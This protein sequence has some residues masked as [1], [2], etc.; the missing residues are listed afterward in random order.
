MKKINLSAFLAALII[1][2]LT[3][4]VSAADADTKE[5]YFLIDNDSLVSTVRGT[6]YLA[7]SWNYDN[8][9]TM[10][11]DT[12]G[13][14]TSTLTD[15]TRNGYT[16]I[17]R[18]FEPQTKGLL[19]FETKLDVGAVK[20]GVHVCFENTQ[21][22]TVLDIFTKNNV[23]NVKT[24][25][26]TK[27]TSIKA[28][29]G[30]V[31]LLAVMDL[32]AKT[33]KVYVD[34]A[35]ACD[36]SLG[37]F[38]D[39]TKLTFSTG[40]EDII[41]FTPKTARLYVNY[42]VY[43]TYESGFLPGDF[44]NS[45]A[46]IAKLVG[47]SLYF[48]GTGTST[49]TFDNI[50]GKVVFEARVY[51]PENTDSAYVSLG[52]DGNE[53]LRIDVSNGNISVHD[54]AQTASF[55]GFSSASLSSGGPRPVMA[56]DTAVENPNPTGSLSSEMFS[57]TMNNKVWQTIHVEADT[58]TGKADLFVNGRIRT[59]FDFS[60]N[61]FDSVTLGA[62]SNSGTQGVY[63]DDVKVYNICDY[64]DYCPQ[65]NPAVSDDYTLIMSV[66]PL[67]REG[68]HYGWDYVSPYEEITPVLGY[69]DEGISETADWEI[70]QM[71]E[72][73]I[74]AM[75]FC[76]YAQGKTKE[77]LTSPHKDNPLD[78]ALHDGYFYAKYK[79][80]VDYCIMWE[81]TTNTS[82]MT[83][84]E[85]KNSLWPF[86]VEY[87]FTDPSYLKI[88][89]KVFF[90]IY[91]YNSFKQIFGS[92]EACKEVIDFMKS[93]ITNYGLDGMIVVF[94]DRGTNKTTVETLKAIG[95]DGVM[96]Y[97]YNEYSYSPSYL[98]QQYSEAVDNVNSVGDVSFIP[99]VANGRNILGW[100]D[101]RS[102]LSSIEQFAEI[103]QYAKD[104]LSEQ[105][106]SSEILDAGIVNFSTW[107]EFAEGH[108]LAPTES[109]G[110]SYADEWRKAFTNA[111]ESHSDAVP[112]QA[113]KARIGHLYND[114]RTPI[115]ALHTDVLAEPSSVMWEE[116][117][118]SNPYN[119]GWGEYGI[120]FSLSPVQDSI[121][122][123]KPSN[124]IPQLKSPENL[125][126]NADEIQYIHIRMKADNVDYGKIFFTN[127]SGEELSE[128]KSVV[129]YLTK[130]GEFVDV[131]VDMTACENWTGTIYK[132]RF[133]L[134]RSRNN[135]QVDF[136]RCLGMSDEQKKLAISVDGTKLEKM[137]YQHI[138][139][140][141]EIYVAAEP[142]K[143]LYSA[144]NFYHEWN[145]FTEELYIKTGT[146]KE[147]VF[148]VG[149]STAKVN[150]ISRTLAAPFYL[151]D[152]IPVL[153][154]KFILDASGID[155]SDSVD[156]FNISV[157]GTNNDDVVANRK[158]NEWLFDVTGDLEGWTASNSSAD[159]VGGDVVL[160]SNLIATTT[161]Y[162][163]QFGN[164]SLSLNAKDYM[165]FE[166]RMQYT[167]LGNKEGSSEQKYMTLYFATDTNNSFSQDQT[168]TCYF[169]SGVD[170][171][172]GY[173]TYTFDV[174]K[175]NLWT[176]TITNL[177]FDPGNNNGLYVIDYIRL[178]EFPAMDVRT[179]DAVNIRL[180]EPNGLR[181]MGILSLESAEAAYE[182]GFI[183]TKEDILKTNG[184]ELTHENW[185]KYGITVV[186]GKAYSENPETPQEP[187]IF[188]R[189]DE[190]L[191]IAG[192]LYGI[193]EKCYDYKLVCRAYALS[194][195]KY[196]YGEPIT[197]SIR[198]VAL[199]L[200]ESGAANSLSEEYK[201]FIYKVAGATL[202]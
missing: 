64:S 176:G 202:P 100:E 12:R 157:R 195:N 146:N 72:H 123:V 77:A 5:A 194:H 134:V 137:T 94:S 14:T 143:G 13:S 74:D 140:D 121:L 7:S 71:A 57:M 144:L 162:D 15:T 196:Y 174:T 1:C 188:D 198:E 160:T 126:L 168:V 4:F 48:E 111:A 66:C 187:I 118:D 58:A 200:V 136:I 185:K 114:Y 11:V 139:K 28:K 81:D 63:F 132:F 156:G 133:D 65:P 61:G 120:S 30:M 86:W 41:T 104:A 127:D 85:F 98:S 40:V 6:T 182:Y 21:G 34:E 88:N 24:L 117:F 9:Y 90:E 191:V 32:D 49:K 80:Y 149:Q 69:Y 23:F 173:K 163:P 145:R 172:D 52:N 3:V 31:N 177:R 110:Y 142:R 27:A 125:S 2:S 130:A 68:S 82:S 16:A 161:G 102:P 183:I 115:R 17:N 184:I 135:F 79:D 199:E 153:P 175:N 124:S 73:G 76:W 105:T 122:T 20:N 43:E 108:W 129:F 51:A 169:S 37:S 116:Q 181:F 103:L 47:D 53:K 92:D 155:Y 84:D 39:F 44:T 60:S 96:P 87:Y 154:M 170:S 62:Y 158:P 29:M 97:A 59:T 25:A 75:Q 109:N 67:W 166:V 55:Y 78:S 93:D 186:E 91:Q 150:G 190:E 83:L 33:A 36:I 128:A 167:Y 56:M 50:S 201:E 147:F 141:D 197:R 138:T 70:K 192:V 151:Q 180:R 178:V 10:D 45:G 95:A 148:T 113:Q 179:D 22:G 19:T 8:R 193:P 131:Y 171:G 35:F 106:T 101:T 107:N 159:A 99:T 112:T 18:S 26:E 152:G 89:N 164:Q 38:T 119:N 54:F 46:T 42:P 189:N 165:S